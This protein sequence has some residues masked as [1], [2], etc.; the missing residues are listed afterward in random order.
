MHLTNGTVQIW[1]FKSRCEIILCPILGAVT[2]IDKSRKFRTLKF[3]LIEQ[4]GCSPELETFL[5]HA[6]KIVTLLKANVDFNTPDIPDG[7]L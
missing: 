5:N 3:D 2:Y 4:F 6:S 7:S 1:F